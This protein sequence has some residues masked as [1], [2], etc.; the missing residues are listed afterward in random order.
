MPMDE[1]GKE[2]ASACPDYWKKNEKLFNEVLLLIKDLKL[3]GQSDYR[4]LMRWRTIA[5]EHITKNELK[6]HLKNKK[7][8]IK[9][10]DEIDK[11]EIEKLKE[12]KDKEMRMKEKKEKKRQRT[13]DKKFKEMIDTAKDMD[14]FHQDE[15]MF[16]IKDEAMPETHL[17]VKDLI[18]NRKSWFNQ[19]LFKQIDSGIDEH[20]QK[21]KQKVE[22]KS[23]SSIKAKS[24]VEDND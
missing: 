6:E 1:N 14:H 7:E 24:V 5:R 2:D 11:D 21:A 4:Q 13:F 3:C 10:D 9:N 18:K 17:R 8:D 20:Y 23:L 15:E 19:D 22:S 16:D 12:M